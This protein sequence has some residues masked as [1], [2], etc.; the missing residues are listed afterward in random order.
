MGHKY[1]S[2]VPLMSLE[3][4]T[5]FE[6]INY[7]TLPTVCSQKKLF[8]SIETLLLPRSIILPIQTLAF[9][10]TFAL[11]SISHWLQLQKGESRGKYY[12]AQFSLSCQEKDVL[13]H[14]I[15]VAPAV[16]GCIFSWAILTLD[17]KSAP[18]GFLPAWYIFIFSKCCLTQ[19]KYL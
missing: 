7:G 9:S 3:L 8:F 12:L 19:K 16:P 14:K 6:S 13:K 1:L 18:Y 5:F 17:D 4:T 11:S 15:W 2:N 10:A